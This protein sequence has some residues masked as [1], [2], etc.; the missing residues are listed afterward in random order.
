MGS[1]LG[2]KIGI[3]EELKDGKNKPN[4]ASLISRVSANKD[5]SSATLKREINSLGNMKKNMEIQGKMTPTIVSLIASTERKIPAMSSLKRKILEGSNP[6]QQFLS[7]QKRF[8]QLQS[9]SRDRKDLESNVEGQVSCNDN[10][11]ESKL[12]SILCDHPTSGVDRPNKISTKDLMVPLDV[13]NDGNVEKAEAYVK[14]LDAICIMLRTKHDEAKEIM[15]R[16][17]VNNNRLLM[18]NHPMF[19]EKISFQ[20]QKFAARLIS[21]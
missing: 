20:V 13:E 21:N 8:S 4:V 11:T 18:L 16:A 17:V 10:Q 3:S 6:D 9:E 5:L 7:P 19:D 1:S 15:V 12:K 2:R 14:E